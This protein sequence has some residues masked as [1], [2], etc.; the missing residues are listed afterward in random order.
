VVVAIANL[1]VG[2]FFFLPLQC[3]GPGTSANPSS[4]IIKNY[5]GIS[6][7]NYDIRRNDA[8][9]SPKKERD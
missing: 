7:V 3:S 9:F 1:F 6:F 2:A 4:K 5:V 8:G